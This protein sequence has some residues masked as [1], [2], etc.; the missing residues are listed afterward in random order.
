MAFVDHFGNSALG[1][2][3]LCTIHLGAFS[4]EALYKHS[5]FAKKTSLATFELLDL[6]VGLVADNIPFAMEMI[7]IAIPPPNKKM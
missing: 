6:H 2:N 1:K 3:P 7:T 4:S 5:T